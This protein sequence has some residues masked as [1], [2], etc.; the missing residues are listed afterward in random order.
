[1]SRTTL[2]NVFKYALAFGLLAG[3]IWWYWEPDSDRG[4][5]R[6]WQKYAIEGQPINGGYLV[7]AFA[8]MAASLSLTLV[9]WYLL[10]RAQGLPC[11]LRDAFR[12][13]LFGFFYNAFLPGSVGGDAVKAAGLALSQKRRTVAVATVVMDRAIALWGLVWFVALLGGAFWALGWLEG[14]A[15]ATSQ[16][17]VTLAGAIVATSVVAWLLLGLLPD[18]RAERFAG[19]L[20]RIPK[21]GTAAAEFW[22]AVWM[23]RCQQRSVATA[24]VLS[25]IGQVGF[26]FTFYFSV[27]ALWD[28][29]AGR[30]PTVAEHFLLVPI[31]LVIQAM[32]GSPGGAGIGEAGFGGL[33]AWFG[34][35]AA[36]AVL[37]SLVQRVIMWTIGLIGYLIA[38]RMPSKSL[39]DTAEMGTE[40]ENHVVKSAHD[41]NLALSMSAASGSQPAEWPRRSSCPQQDCGRGLVRIQQ[42]KQ[43]GT[44]V[45]DE[46]GPILGRHDEA[47]PGS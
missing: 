16:R 34:C 3:V 21:V 31:G 17:I 9:R 12:L 7:L 18:W 8:V 25:W 42:R 13:G 27:L 36:V 35:A 11:R 28:P 15:A 40:R 14:P 32:P 43:T 39:A 46:H 24:L 22:R 20:A 5:A 2:W 23:Y 37:G 19:R 38:L 45:P 1:M 4:L 10:V 30:I 47:A 29:S 33:Y 44:G 26:V 41:S 6:V